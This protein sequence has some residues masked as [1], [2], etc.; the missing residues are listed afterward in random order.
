MLWLGGALQTQPQIVNTTGS[1][2]DLAKTIL[3][4]LNM[5]SSSFVW[6]R[7]LFAEKSNPWAYFTFNN[8]FGWVK[9]KKNYFIYDNV[10]KR[11][12]AKKGNIDSIDIK[13]GKALQQNSFADYLSK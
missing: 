6:S 1:Q 4:Q 9:N 11:I 7:D 10:G 5:N 2:I 13:S 3:N 12:M 8:G